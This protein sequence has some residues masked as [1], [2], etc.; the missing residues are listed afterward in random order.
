MA[1]LFETNKILMKLYKQS[2]ECYNQLI[3]G[4]IMHDHIQQGK[5][6]AVSQ[7]VQIGEDSNPG[8]DTVK[9]MEINLLVSFMKDIQPTSVEKT[10]TEKITMKFE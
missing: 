5:K 2:I 4:V 3:N 1:L 10:I 9:N 6:L 8:I 7:L